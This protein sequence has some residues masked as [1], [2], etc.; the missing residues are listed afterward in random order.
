MIKE[1]WNG[2]V[3]RE[4]KKI[5]GVILRMESDGANR[6]PVV[7]GDA[8]HVARKKG[9]K[10]EEVGEKREYVLTFK[11]KT[12][13]PNQAVKKMRTAF[14]ECGLNQYSFSKAEAE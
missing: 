3:V 13:D 8:T 4:G 5:K 7:N 6:F 14:Q 9:K 11:I 1:K 10:V 2:F 12:M